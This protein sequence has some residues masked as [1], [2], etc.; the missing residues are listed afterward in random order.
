MNDLNNEDILY[1]LKATFEIDI[2]DLSVILPF[3]TL[4]KYGKGMLFLTEGKDVDKLGIIKSGIT[5]EYF[6]AKEKEITKF[7]G[8]AGNLISDVSGINFNTPARWT[9][10][11]VTDCDIYVL[12]KNDI[13]VIQEKLPNWSSIQARFTAKCLM[14]AEN[15]ILE[16]LQLNAEERYLK[17]LQEKPF[18]F[19]YVELRH[20]ASYLGITPET[21]S[22]FRNKYSR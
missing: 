4:K 20:I 21:L 17:L 14:S 22:R 19:N 7:I 1:I 11:M 8:T 6:I 2:D 10:E 9:I 15:R 12:N 5:R 13:S 18:I 3:F 16:H